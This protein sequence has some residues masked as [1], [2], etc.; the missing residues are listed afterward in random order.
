MP[1][2][3][4]EWEKGRSAKGRSAQKEKRARKRARKSQEKKDWKNRKERFSGR[5]CD[6]CKSDQTIFG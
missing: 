3:S 5:V 4:R 1:K 2:R 6:L